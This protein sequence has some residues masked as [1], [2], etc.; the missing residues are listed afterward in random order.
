MAMHSDFRIETAREADIPMIL[1][2]LHSCADSLPAL[3]QDGFLA[4]L[5]RN[6]RRGSALTLRLDTRVSGICVWSPI[7][8]RI[9]LLAVHRDSRGMGLA[10]ALLAETLR[11]MPPGDVTVETFRDGDSRGRAALALYRKFGFQHDSLPEGFEIPMQ[12][13][14]LCRD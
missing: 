14:R 7:L 8:R 9:S 6:I 2:I 3:S 10:S 4:L 13:L 12:I 11:R 5:Q 1:E